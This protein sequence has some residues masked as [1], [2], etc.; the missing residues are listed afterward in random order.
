MGSIFAPTL[1]RHFGAR[2]LAY[3]DEFMK[4]NYNI[5][6]GAAWDVFGHEE[7]P[8]AVPQRIVLLHDGVRIR[9]IR[10]SG[11][12]NDPNLV[13]GRPRPRTPI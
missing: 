3:P 5:G 8:V 4:N 6:Y 13:P 11:S 1:W 12:E 7:T 10:N 9:E 2:Y